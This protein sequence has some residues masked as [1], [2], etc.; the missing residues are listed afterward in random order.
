MGFAG[1]C[2]AC[3]GRVYPKADWAPRVFR[4]KTTFEGIARDSVQAYFH[5]V[6]ILRDDMRRET[7]MLF[8]FLLR[9]NRPAEELISA[10]Y[11]FL[12]Q[13][14]AEF[15]GIDGVKGVGRA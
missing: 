9:E 1:P 7:E 6:S 5:S 2:S 3:L 8:E 10:R 13:R 14:L 12:N 11:S 15:Y 4:A